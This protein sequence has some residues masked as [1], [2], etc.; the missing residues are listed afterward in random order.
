MTFGALPGYGAGS[1][2]ESYRYTFALGRPVR[3]RHASPSPRWQL[4][5]V[6]YSPKHLPNR[7]GEARDHNA[8]VR[9]DGVQLIR[10]RT[11]KGPADDG[12]DSYRYG[13]RGVSFDFMAERRVGRGVVTDTWKVQLDPRRRRL[14]GLSSDLRDKQGATKVAEIVGNIEE[15]RYAWPYDR[16]NDYETPI[17]CVVFLDAI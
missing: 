8:L 5:T 1:G 3:T 10:I 15:A 17:K 9:D 14:N 7:E 2:F 6:S 11:L 16:G 13:D 12:P 4:R